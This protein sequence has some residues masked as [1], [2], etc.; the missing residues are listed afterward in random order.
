[1]LYCPICLHDIDHG[2]FVTLCNHVFHRTCMKLCLVSH[3]LCPICRRG[4]INMKN[5]KRILRIHKTDS[6]GCKR[7]ELVNMEGKTISSFP[8]WI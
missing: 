3:S 1:M 8:L 7:T 2:L 5:S 6:F 4:G